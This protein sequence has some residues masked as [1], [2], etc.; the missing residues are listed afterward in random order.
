MQ[1]GAPGVENI[2]SLYIELETYKLATKLL[3]D[4]FLASKNGI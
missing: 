3:V 4:G 1:S 2:V